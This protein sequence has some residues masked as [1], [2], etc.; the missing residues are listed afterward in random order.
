MRTGSRLASRAKSFLRLS[1][2]VLA[3]LYGLPS[4]L[5]AALVKGRLAIVHVLF[6]YG[7]KRTAQKPLP[8]VSPP[9][10]CRV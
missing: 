6:S 8:T 3:L 10:I 1:P 4:M 5:G 2:R 9:P 7:V